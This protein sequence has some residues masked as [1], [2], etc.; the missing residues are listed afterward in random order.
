MK[1][2]TIPIT[3]I[4]ED[5]FIG[6][7]DGVEFPFEPGEKRHFPSF[8]SNH[9]ANQMIQQI[10]KDTIDDNEKPRK[11]DLRTKIL[12]EEIM[13]AEENK[14]LTFK[15]EVEEHEREFA[16]MQEDKKR[17]EILKR[18]KAKDILGKIENK[19]SGETAKKGETTGKEKNV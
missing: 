4:R 2:N 7:Y 8:L 14:K 5:V 19:D 12:E 9:I 3:N 18:D 17:E 10:M 13:T 6:K 16:K 11:E 1:Y 15:E